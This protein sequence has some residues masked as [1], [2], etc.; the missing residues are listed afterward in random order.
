MILPKVDVIFYWYDD[1]LLFKPL[2]PQLEK[3]VTISEKKFVKQPHRAPEIQYQKRSFI[4]MVSR[5]GEQ[6]ASTYQGFL[7]TLVQACL[8]NNITFFIRDM[9]TAQESR[10]FPAPRLDLMHGF[11][12]SQEDLL[13]EALSKGQSGLIGAPTRYGKTALM[14]N[15]IRA[16]PTLPTVVTAPG[17]D[18]C[19]Q[20]F[21]DITGEW[22]IKDREVKLICSGSKTRYPSETGI[23]ICSADSLSKCDSGGTQLLLADEPHQLVTAARAEMINAFT[24]ARRYGFGATLK[25][26]F[27]G[28]DPLITGLFGPVLAERTYLDAVEEGAICPLC[29]IFININISDTNRCSTHNAA[30]KRLLFQNADMA[31]VTARICREIVPDDF[32]TMIFIDN[33][34]QAN[35]YFD[36]IGHEGSIVLAMAKKMTDKE[37]EQITEDMRNGTIKRCLCTDIYVQGVTFP[38]VRVLINCEGGGNNTSAIQKPGRLAQVRPGKKCGVIFDFAFHCLSSHPECAYDLERDSE[39]RRSAYKEKGYTIYDAYSMEEAKQI[40]DSII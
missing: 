38:D 22:G 11:R 8:K 10:G 16:F 29:I 5:N 23:T 19:R 24:V 15:T 25:G 30:Y 33:E 12:H 6:V 27:D 17:V 9:R 39:A 21:D 32:Q 2:L 26:R 3:A 13:T 1:V 7:H 18:L 20:L 35:L 37:R 28:R 36:K 4:S 31:G 14:V 34:K 40:F